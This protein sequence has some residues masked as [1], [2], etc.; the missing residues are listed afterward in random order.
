MGSV[1]CMLLLCAGSASYHCVF[2]NGSCLLCMFA[3][4][5]MFVRVLFTCCCLCGFPGAAFVCWLCLLCLCMS[6]GLQ[7]WLCV[8]VCVFVLLLVNIMCVF[9]CVLGSR[10]SFGM[11]SWVSFAVSVYRFCVF[12][13]CFCGLLFVASGDDFV[14]CLFVC[15]CVCRFCVLLFCVLASLVACVC[16]PLLIAFVCWLHLLLPRVDSVRR[17]L[18]LSRA[19]LLWVPL[20]VVGFRVSVLCVGFV[21][22]GCM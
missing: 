20:A 22:C 8:C 10:V 4:C 3:D 13:C 17:F 11:C 5:V 18:C 14:C 19:L 15:V 12:V 1:C 6:C 16:W 7:C 2:G 21:C 9:F